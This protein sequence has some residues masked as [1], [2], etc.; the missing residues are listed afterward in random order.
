M[1]LMERATNW[2]RLSACFRFE[3][4]PTELRNPVE[5]KHALNGESD[6]LEEIERA[7]V[8]EVLEREKGNKARAAR[9]LGI[10]RRSLYRLLEKYGIA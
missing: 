6:K 3:D 2:K 1:R 5:G 4:L 9:A 7:H 8:L 10:N